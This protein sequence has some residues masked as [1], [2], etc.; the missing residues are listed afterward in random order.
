MWCCNT[1]A[2]TCLDPH[3]KEQ[4]ERFGVEMVH[5]KDWDASSTPS[6]DPPVYLTIDMDALDPAFA[7]GVSHHEPGG[8]TTRD[9]LGIIQGLPV[10]PV[11]ADIVEFNP[12]RDPTGITAAL[13]CKLLKEILAR[14]LS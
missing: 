13:A 5:M 8:F 3:Q 12:E 4:A 1:P 11:G 9:V 7:P 14:M 6:V 2:C 10:A